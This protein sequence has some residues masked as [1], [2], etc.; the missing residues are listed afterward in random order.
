M[1]KRGIN[2]HFKLIEC[3]FYEID[4]QERITTSFYTS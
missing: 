3:Y 2:I 4:K 1:I